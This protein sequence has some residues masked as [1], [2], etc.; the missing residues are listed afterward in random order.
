MA[1]DDYHVIVFRFLSYLYECL[2]KGEKVDSKA[3]EQ[4]GPVFGDVP[5]SYRR[6]VY[7][8]LWNSGYIETLEGLEITCAGIEYLASATLMQQ[9]RWI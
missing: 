6:F 4:G 2:K 1:K 9:A 3:F 7:T 8:S 5:E